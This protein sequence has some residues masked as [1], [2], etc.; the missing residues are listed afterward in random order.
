MLP[1]GYSEVAPGKVATVV[2]CLE[3]LERGHLRAERDAASWRLRHVQ[4]PEAAWYRGLYA[5]V[6]VDWLWFS[7]LAMP[8]AELEGIIRHADVEVYALEE[9][10]RDEGLLELDFRTPGECELAFYGL[11][12]RA[13]RPGS[14]ALADEP[15]DRARVGAADPSLLGPHLHLGP[16]RSAWLLHPVGIQALRTPRRSRRRSA[17]GGPGAPHERAARPHHRG[18]AKPA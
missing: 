4:R 5:H 11:E 7:R 15:R 1:D 12:R 14:R 13:A 17:V 2:T 8:V 9:A 10:G 3:M 16:P 18:A 6:G